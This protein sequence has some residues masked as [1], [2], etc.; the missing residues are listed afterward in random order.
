METTK[1]GECLANGD[2]FGMGGWFVTRSDLVPASAM[3]PPSLTI[4][5]PNGPP[6][7]NSCACAQVQA[8][9]A[10]RIMIDSSARLNG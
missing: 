10:L 4:T 3:M 8:L 5:A 9:A 7:Q 1:L 6:Q 2:D